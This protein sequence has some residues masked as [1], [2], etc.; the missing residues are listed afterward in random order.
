MVMSSKIVSLTFVLYIKVKNAFARS[1]KIVNMAGCLWISLESLKNRY[2][3]R[4]GHVT[5]VGVSKFPE[6][7]SS[8]RANFVVMCV[9]VPLVFVM[10]RHK[11]GVPSGLSLTKNVRTHNSVF[12]IRLSLTKNVR[13]PNS[14]CGINRLDLFG[15]L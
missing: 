9:K 8:R 5:K 4:W 14:A 11:F 7:K 3:Y 10:P 13:T 1:T 6:S 15:L 2:Q 12:P